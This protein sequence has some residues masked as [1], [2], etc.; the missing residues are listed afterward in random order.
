MKCVQAEQ[1]LSQQL[2]GPLPG[3]EVGLLETHLGECSACRRLQEELLTLRSGLR[4]LAQQ[5][6]TAEVERPAIDRWLAERAAPA[7][8]GWNGF[9]PG[10]CRYDF[11][12]ITLGD[13][14]FLRNV[15]VCTSPTLTFP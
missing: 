4:A 1:L 8:H 15:D 5:I 6:P 7:G 2:E 12:G 11:K 14:V 13:D 9:R 10:T 3:R